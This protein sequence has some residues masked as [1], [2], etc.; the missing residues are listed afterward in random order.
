MGGS[1]AGQVRNPSAVIPILIETVLSSLSNLHGKNGL[2]TPITYP[3]P[4]RLF[5]LTASSRRRKRNTYKPN[6][7]DRKHPQRDPSA[8]ENKGYQRKYE[9]AGADDEFE[10]EVPNIKPIFEP[11]GG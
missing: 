2:H 8:C 7:W 6:A 3:S 10:E 9:G 4:N 5:H 1:E 11:N